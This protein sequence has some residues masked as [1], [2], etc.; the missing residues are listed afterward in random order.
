VI[1][2]C[3]DLG[4]WRDHR[5]KNKTMIALRS[6]VVAVSISASA[7]LVLFFGAVGVRGSYLASGVMFAA[8]LAF[9]LVT[10][11]RMRF[12]L[13]DWV[14]AA[15]VGLV[16][17]SIAVNGVAASAKDYA[18]LFLSLLAYPAFRGLG[19]GFNRG[20]F[21]FITGAVVVAGTIATAI[22]IMRD[23]MASG[24][25]PAV[26]GF[27]EASVYF[28]K[29]FAFILFALAS[30]GVSLLG[31]L[32][33]VI[34]PCVVFPAAMVRYPFVGIVAG[35]VVI[36]LTSAR[37]LQTA[38]ICA[39]IVAAFAVGMLARPATSERLIGYVAS[40]IAPSV[41]ASNDSSAYISAEHADCGPLN[42]RDSIAIRKALT[43]EALAMIPSA[44]FFGIGLSG[45]EK[46]S[47]MKQYPHNIFLQTAV[48]LGLPA[49]LLLV[50]LLAIA[51]VAALGDSFVAASLVFVCVEAIFSG[52][53]TGAMLLFGFV[54]WAVGLKEA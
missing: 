37:R 9:L 1:P 47:C 38:A 32:A 2:H 42:W 49:A 35:L 13:G 34:V 26:F 28:A 48:E 18:L 51:F 50:A 44:G 21:I 43:R 31:F 40:A 15:F 3:V 19:H 36:G 52:A 53:L 27:P 8:P 6:V 30:S 23:E 11:P 29:S 5:N 45:F 54:G 20:L 39:A 24:S 22:F 10:S 12:T 46:T 33:A 14:F 4:S 25:H 17:V 41:F 7:I 16:A